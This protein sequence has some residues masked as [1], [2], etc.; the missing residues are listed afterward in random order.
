M[1]SSKSFEDSEDL[2][3]LQ[4]NFRPENVLST[5]T[6]KNKTLLIQNVI[7]EQQII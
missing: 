6:Y 4:I 7:F 2:K 5:V 1:I 3:S